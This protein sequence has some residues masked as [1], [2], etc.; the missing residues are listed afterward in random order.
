MIDL[1]EKLCPKILVTDEELYHLRAKWR[2][3][4]LIKVLGT[5]LRNFVQEVDAAVATQRRAPGD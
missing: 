3:S 2:G 4:F 1:S 5:W